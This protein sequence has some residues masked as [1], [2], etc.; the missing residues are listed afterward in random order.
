[1]PFG[2]EHKPLD[3]FGAVFDRAGSTC[4]KPCRRML[5]Q[6]IQPLHRIKVQAER[7]SQLVCHINSP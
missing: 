1:M 6:A 7:R 5:H 3:H 4:G 2:K